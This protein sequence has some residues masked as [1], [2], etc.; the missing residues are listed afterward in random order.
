MQ[1]ATLVTMIAAALLF[2][3]DHPAVAGTKQPEMYT[4]TSWIGLA[5]HWDF[6]LFS[7]TY[8]YTAGSIEEL[9]Q[10]LSKLPPGTPIEW[11]SPPGKHFVYPPEPMFGEIRRFLSERHFKLVFTH[12]ARKL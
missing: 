6:A 1:R 10:H 3:L 5:G 4:L 11:Y 12:K 7:S 8:W 2:T 9:K